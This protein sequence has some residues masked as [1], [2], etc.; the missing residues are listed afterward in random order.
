[1][2]TMRASFTVPDRQT[3]RRTKGQTDR[4]TDERRGNSATIRSTNASRASK[5]R[6]AK[7]Y[8]IHV[9]CDLFVRTSVFVFDLSS[10]FYLNLALTPAAAKLPGKLRCF[11]NW[12]I[13]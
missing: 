8:V 6:T 11:N 4:E 1:M 12:V 2:I 9:L 3:N 5:N 13:K 10:Q 7:D